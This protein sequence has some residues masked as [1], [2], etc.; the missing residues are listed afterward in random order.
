MPIKKILKTE[1]LLPTLVFLIPLLIYSVT[2]TGDFVYDDNVQV[3]GNP[4]IRDFSKIPALF[5]SSTMSYVPGQT[6]NTYRPVFYIIYMVEYFFFG[7]RPW[8][9]H[10]VNVVLH[11]MNALAL[12]FLASILITTKDH[13][14]ATKKFTQKKSA[15][16]IP[17]F[18]ALVFAL[19]PINSE[20]VAWV[21]TI[22]ELVY[23]LMLLS[24]F[25]LY[26]LAERSPGRA[27]PYLAFSI[28]CFF[29][30]LLSKE[31]G[32]ALI[33][34]IPLYEFSRHGMKSLRRW[35]VFL[36]YLVVAAI[37]MALR[38][39]ALGG[40]T[41]MRIMNMTFYEGLLNVLPLISRYLGKLLMPINLSIVYSFEPVHSPLDIMFIIGVL[42][43]AAFGALIYYLRKERTLAFFLIWILIPLLPVLYMP[44]LSIGGFADRYLYLSTVG[45]ACFAATLVFKVSQKLRVEEKHTTLLSAAL[46]LV[47]LLNSAASIKRA[48]VWRNDYSLWSDTVTKSPNSH[49]VLYNLGWALHRK[50]GQDNLEKALMWYKE[51]IRVKPD[52]EEAHYNSALIYQNSGNDEMALKHYMVSL[53]LRP[54]HPVTYYNIAM[55]YQAQGRLSK[56]IEFY[57]RALNINP[58]YEDAHYNL[59]WAYQ[60]RG[61]YDM[62]LVHYREVLRLSPR[63]AETHYNIGV[64]YEERGL[65]GRAL[66]EYQKAL[67]ANP[68]YG[69]AGFKIERLLGRGR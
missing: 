10:L 13:Y 34:I 16:L 40:M 69:P 55:I 54:S 29:A 8:A 56:A 44:I 63:S 45:F 20:V 5:V 9:W 6:A 4:W 30:A 1:Y 49:Y 7:L 24:A 60:E 53:R 21:G 58:D 33:I 27:V 22:P 32:M 17:F 52:K 46:V 11:G 25:I 38:T 18:A 43:S 35:K 50:G 23:T 2:L 64:I 39:H 36:C 67:E 14:T 41:Q 37:Y 65:P 61:D 59:A 15:P 12:Y 26:L 48:L 19:H 3:I 57:K 47:L 31:T 42:A 51:A 66:R 68:E 28:A 62:A